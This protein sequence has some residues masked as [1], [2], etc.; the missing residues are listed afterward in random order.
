MRTMG[1]SS[2]RFSGASGYLF[3]C[4][5]TETGNKIVAGGADRVLRVWNGEDGAELLKIEP[6]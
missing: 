6:K 2:A 3:C 4:A 1:R 5:A